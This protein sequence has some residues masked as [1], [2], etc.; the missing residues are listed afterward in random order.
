MPEIERNILKKLCF[1]SGTADMM[2]LGFLNFG[3]TLLVLKEV[4]MKP[5]LKLIYISMGNTRFKNTI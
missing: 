4:E 2:Y 5:C 3:R 1:M